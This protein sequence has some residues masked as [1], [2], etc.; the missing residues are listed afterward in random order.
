MKRSTFIRYISLTGIGLTLTSSRL[1]ALTSRPR[2][3]L[4]KTEVHIP[5]G[6]FAAAKFPTTMIRE[7][8]LTVS[9]Q[10]F[11][12]CGIAQSENDLNVYIFKRKDEIL[13]M[14]LN[15]KGSWQSGS[16]KGIELSTSYKGFALQNQ[17]YQISIDLG[18]SQIKLAQIG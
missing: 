15:S 1:F 16:L 10:R 12:A 18:S 4:P 3:V 17:V 5:H 11:L 14:G 6:N 7:L 9:V 2:L 13:V 8:N